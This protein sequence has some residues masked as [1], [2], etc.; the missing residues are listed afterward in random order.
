[1]DRINV[2]VISKPG[3]PHLSVLKELPESAQV[4]LGNSV[5]ELE[6]VIADTQVILNGNFSPQPFRT[7]FPKAKAVRW[8]HSLSA[9]VEAVLSPEVI[10]SDIPLTNARGVFKDSLAEFGIAA[11]LFFA[12]DLHRML[13]NQ[14]AERWEPFDVDMLQGATLGVV[15]YGEIGRAT[16]RLAHAFGMKVLA[17]R[18]RHS[19]SAEDPLLDGA[20]PPDQLG[21]MLAACDYVLVAAPNTPETHHMMNAAAFSRMKASAVI[22]NVG[23]GPVIDEEALIEALESKR[24]RGAALDVFEEEPLPPG[25]P[26]YAMQNVLV[27]PHCADHTKGWLESA[28]HKFVENYKLFE[29]GKPLD[30]VVDKKAG[31]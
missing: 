30:N 4:T 19:L 5:E 10:A 17:L 13:R 20:Y 2:V 12:K 3:L 28:M 26:L 8:I 11:M 15:G 7:L 23:R 21:E 25:N 29:A 22:I 27:S 16:A 9:G 1:M 14:H 18:R 31:Y 24:I 6:P